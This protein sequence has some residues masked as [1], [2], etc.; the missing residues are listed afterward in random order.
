MDKK[1]VVIEDEIEISHAICEHL[2][3]H[4]FV[5]KSYNDAE[6]FYADQSK[7][8]RAIYLV[9]WN[10]PGVNGIDVIKKLREGDKF[11]PIFMI[12]ANTSQEHMLE[13][14]K[15]GADDYITKPF[16]FDNLLLRVQNSW[17]KYSELSKDLFSEGIKLLPEAHSLLKDGTT[18]NL[19]AREFIIFKHLHDT[20]A[21]VSRDE[22][23]KQFVSDE[24]MTIRNIDVHVFSLRKKLKNV[25]IT[26]ATVWGAG[27]KLDI[28][29]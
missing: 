4:G 25:G 3:S 19:T 2:E 22:I 1:V 9:D 17:Q 29:N 10:L 6:S 28:E 16:H 24:D 11:S 13:G 14:L 18:V 23:I 5:P 7:P 12:T 20:Q 27:Y 26:I 21:T 15:A 8:L